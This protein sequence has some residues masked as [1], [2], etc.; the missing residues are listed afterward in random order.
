MDRPIKDETVEKYQ[1]AYSGD[2]RFYPFENPRSPQKTHKRWQLLNGDHDD[3][4]WYGIKKSFDNGIFTYPGKRTSKD[5]PDW[6]FNPDGYFSGITD[7]RRLLGREG[8][9]DENSQEFKDWQKKLNEL[10]YETYLDSD[11][12][13]GYGDRYYKLRRI[14]TPDPGQQNDGSQLP[15]ENK[16]NP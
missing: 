13:T 3:Y 7:Y 16:E 11:E 8:D 4:N 15:E 9:W 6:N 10:G 1:K 5:N 12:K 2:D 14:G